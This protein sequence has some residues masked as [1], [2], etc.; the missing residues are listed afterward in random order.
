MKICI[1]FQKIETENLSD[2]E[3]R[4]IVSKT[5]ENMMRRLFTNWNLRIKSDKTVFEECK[6]RLIVFT[7]IIMESKKSLKLQ[8]QNFIIEVDWREELHNWII[9][10]QMQ[11]AQF[12]QTDIEFVII[13][14]TAVKA[15]SQKLLW[16]NQQVSM[17]D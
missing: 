5:E 11:G 9:L 2:F 10:Q 12:L 15:N 16:K 13:T 3:K 7:I 14:S 8:K 1:K 17:E 6:M 4:L